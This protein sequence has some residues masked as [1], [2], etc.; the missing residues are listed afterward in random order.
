[1]GLWAACKEETSRIKNVSIESSGGG[2]ICLW[3]KE[4]CTHRKIPSII[5]MIN[6][7]PVSYHWNVAVS[8]FSASRADPF[9][10]Q[11]ETV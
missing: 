1:M 8:Q 11:S 7:K 2:K 5:I 9:R 6:P 4:N 10:E 3:V